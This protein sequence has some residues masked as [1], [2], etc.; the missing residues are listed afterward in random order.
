MAAWRAGWL[1][2]RG[3][4]LDQV[5][6][7]LQRYTGQPIAA[8]PRAAA[9]PVTA[10]IRIARAGKWLQA[11]PRAMPLRAEPHAGGWRIAERWAGT[12]VAP[13]TPTGSTHH[14]KPIP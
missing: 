11:L 9:M 1:G 3:A 2:F 6:Q 7:R 4:S 8:T 12:S 13:R 10:E 5:V 14:R